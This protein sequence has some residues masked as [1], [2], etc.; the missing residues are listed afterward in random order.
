MTLQAKKVFM[1]GA[2]Y[3]LFFLRHFCEKKKN[4]RKEAWTLRN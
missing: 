2:V 3:L 4:V 1:R